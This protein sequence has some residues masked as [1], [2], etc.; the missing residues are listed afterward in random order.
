MDGIKV[1]EMVEFYPSKVLTIRRLSAHILQP[2]SLA[3][4]PSLSG[5]RGLS[6]LPLFVTR[7]GRVLPRPRRRRRRQP[8]HHG[9]NLDRISLRRRRR[10][11][12]QTK[13]CDTP[14]PGD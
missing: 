10:R 3:V 4:L 1:I 9:T 12:L 11:R 13:I 8:L 7:D 2:F 6:F 14:I 5:A